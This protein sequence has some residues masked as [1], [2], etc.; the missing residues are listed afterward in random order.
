V[1]QIEQGKSVVVHVNRLKR[2]HESP[3]WTQNKVGPEENKGEQKQIR[4][5]D[6]RQNEIRN[7][8][9]E[10]EEEIPPSRLP[11]EGEND[12]KDA[13]DIGNGDSSPE[14]RRQSDWVPETQYLWRKMSR[15]TSK[16]LGSSSDIPYD[17]R[18]RSTRTQVNRDT[19]DL[20]TVSTDMTDN[21]ETA[22]GNNL[23]NIPVDVSPPRMP[24]YNL[25]SRT[26]DFV[27][28]A[29]KLKKK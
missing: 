19:I 3:K 15:E 28:K 6:L 10:E 29:D 5:N 26:L 7:D 24:P 14:D 11:G 20:D 4:K 16:S 25:R 18:S 22:S 2:A 23:E 17:L 27:R 13:D 8:F 12:D 1:L 9:R 21:R